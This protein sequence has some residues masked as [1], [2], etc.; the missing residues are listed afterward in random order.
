MKKP[1]A[2]PEPHSMA[3]EHHSFMNPNLP[4]FFQ[5]NR[6]YRDP[7]EVVKIFDLYDV[8]VKSHKPISSIPKTPIAPKEVLPLHWNEDIEIIYF[9][10]G[11]TRIDYPEGSIDYHSGDIAI[12]TPDKFHKI[13]PVT[14]DVFYSFIIVD[15][16]FL[17]S[18][19]I[20]I[21]K[22]LF[23][24]K[25]VDSEI[26]SYFDCVAE[27]LINNDNPLFDIKTMAWVTLICEK[28]Y[29][30]YRITESVSS[31]NSSH[32]TICTDVIKY[33]AK[34]FREQINLENIASEIGVSKYHMCRCFKEHTGY[35]IIDY[36]NIYKLERAR[37]LITSGSMNLTEAAKYCGYSNLSYFSRIFKNVMGVTPK[38]LKVYTNTQEEH[39]KS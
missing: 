12:I 22:H 35:S 30:H 10:D 32:F 34:N 15:H 5:I 16:N 33:V 37:E 17:L 3:Y 36:A 25:I 26:S 29:S 39:K 28:L 2:F 6:T 23:Q 38:A 18:K 8:V 20:D 31:S 21:N 11:V 9:I 19:R 13:R 27:S 14:E 1:N 24:P 4:I 7:L